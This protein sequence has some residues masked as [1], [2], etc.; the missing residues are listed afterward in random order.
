M[1]VLLFKLFTTKFIITVWRSKYLRFTLIEVCLCYFSVSRTCRRVF[2]RSGQ[3]CF[4]FPTP[5]TALSFDVPVL[6]AAAA[7]VP[8]PVPV[9]VVVAGTFVFVFVFVAD[10]VAVV[11]V[12]DVAVAVVVVERFPF[13]GSSPSFLLVRSESYFPVLLLLLLNLLLLLGLGLYLLRLVF[14]LAALM[15]P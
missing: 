5:A 14:S 11:V 12:V 6:A 2:R 10:A 8:V 3:D 13:V 4:V 9:V 1:L 15:H 7:G